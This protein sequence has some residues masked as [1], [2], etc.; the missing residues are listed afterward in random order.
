MEIDPATRRSLEITRTLFGD[1]RSLLAA[2]DQTI[3]AGGA[4]L[5]AQRIGHLW[6]TLRPSTGGLISWFATT[7]DLSDTFAAA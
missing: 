3:T 7:P 2:I 5:L 4:R 6:R 1:R